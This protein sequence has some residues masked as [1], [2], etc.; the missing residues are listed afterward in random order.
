[1]E[2][3][4]PEGFGPGKRAKK[5]PQPIQA[6][7]GIASWETAVPE[8]WDQEPLN[9]EVHCR[10]FR[11]CRYCEADGPRE[12]CSQL[13]GLCNHWLKPERH[14]K[15]QI[16]DLVILE[17]FLTILPQ[18][19]QH[20]VR[21]CGPETS[22]QAVALAEGFLLSQVE[23][24]RQAEQSWGPS[25]K[26]EAEFCE[27]EGVLLEEGQRAQEHA[28][29]ALSCG[30]E[31]AV[32]IQSLCEGVETAVAPPVQSSV[33]FGEVAMY[34]TKTEWALLD[35]DQKA[36]YREVM[37]ENYRSVVSLAGDDQWKVGDEELHHLLTDEVKSEDLKGSFRNQGQPKRQKVCH[38]VEKKD[39]PI[40]GKGRDFHERSHM[41]DEAYKCL[42]CGMNFS[43]QN[44][45]DNHLQMHNGKKTH[46]C[47]ECGKSF[48]HRAELLR[49]QRTH[50]GEKPYS[51]SD[52][53]KSSHS[54]DLFEH[55]RIHSAQNP[56]IFTESGRMFSCGRKGNA[57]S[58]KH[59]IMG[60]HKCFRCGKNFRYRSK[61]LVHQKIHTGEKPFECSE[62]GKRFS[63]SGHLQQH[64]RT[65]TGEKPFECSECGRRFSHSSS[66]KKHQ[67]THTGE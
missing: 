7:S 19:M 29:D 61:L 5:C 47:L 2:E 10:R 37:L 1:M 57:L 58:P 42:E 33:S 51:D 65:H 32:L 44:Q 56:F 21:G 16:L 50:K 59:R 64:Q 14:T 17:Q 20:W 30:S 36:L 67:R 38:M 31:E 22:S 13:H 35:P 52:G 8:I 39:K 63:R 25:M 62:C 15:K 43:D 46:Q 48:L 11:Q 54:S 4:D 12:V 40:S 60:A 53:G 26:M 3:Q 66:L 6:G 27:T 28:Q 18:A 55:K 24:K 23:E 49:H 41:V 34:F 45:Y 9:S